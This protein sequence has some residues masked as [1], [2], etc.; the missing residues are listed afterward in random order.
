MLGAAICRWEAKGM[1]DH[2]RASPTG[3]DTLASETWRLNGQHQ[4]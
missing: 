4:T 3:G 1:L 2:R